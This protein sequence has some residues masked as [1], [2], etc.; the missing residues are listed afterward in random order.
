MG[1]ELSVIASFAAAL[2]MRGVYYFHIPSTMTSI[3]DSCI[4]GKTAINYNNK[5]NY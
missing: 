1:G 5:I 4:G 3:L 2:Y